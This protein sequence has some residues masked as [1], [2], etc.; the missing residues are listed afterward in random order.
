M[1]K[2]QCISHY[3]ILHGDLKEGTLVKIKEFKIEL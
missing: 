1:S 2:F 3:I